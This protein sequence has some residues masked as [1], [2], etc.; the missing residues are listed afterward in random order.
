MVSV[1]S[2]TMDAVSSDSIRPTSASARDTGPMMSSVSS[3][4][5]TFGM[6]NGGSVVGNAPMPP[7]SISAPSGTNSAATVSTTMAT[8]GLGTAFVRYGRP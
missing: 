8:S 5:G 3:V 6:P 2:S 4:S 7:T 1:I